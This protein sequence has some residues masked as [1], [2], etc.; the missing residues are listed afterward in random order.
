[1]REDGSGVQTK[2]APKDISD[3]ASMEEVVIHALKG[4]NLHS[5]TISF[6]YTNPVFLFNVDDFWV[7][8]KLGNKRSMGFLSN[9]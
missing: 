4:K 6:R 1:M 2:E 3:Y 9:I 8:N 7:F 5:S